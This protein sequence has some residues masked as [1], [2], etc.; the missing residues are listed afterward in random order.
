MAHPDDRSR[1]GRRE[2]AARTGRAHGIGA[3]ELASGRR[4]DLGPH[5]LAGQLHPVADPQNRQAQLEDRR[6]A[7]GRSGFVDTRRPARE[8]QGQRVQLANALGRDVVAD[9]P[10]KRMPLANPA[11][12]ELDILSTEIKDQYGSRRRVGIRHELLS[13]KDQGTAESFVE[14]T[15]RFVHQAYQTRSGLHNS[16]NRRPP[17]LAMAGAFWRFCAFL[18]RPHLQSSIPETS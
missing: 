10:R 8:D 1:A 12:D 13:C 9:D 14:C 16:P 17:N 6:I 4:I 5:R 18:A 11:R 2:R 15:Y 7:L 3:A